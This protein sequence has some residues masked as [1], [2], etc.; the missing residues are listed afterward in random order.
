MLRVCGVLLSSLF[1]NGFAN[2]DNIY[3]YVN[4]PLDKKGPSENCDV[5]LCSSLIELIESS[6]S[7]I[8]FAIYGLR[9]QPYI[10]KALER[11]KNRGVLVRGIVD[12]TTENKSYYSDTWR[13]ERLIT[14]T[15]SDLEHD[16]RTLKKLQKRNNWSGKE[17]CDRPKGHV[18]PLQCFEGEGYASKADINFQGDIMHHKFF[19]V[20]SAVVWSGS[21][22]ISDTGVGGYNANNVVVIESQAVAQLFTEEFNRMFQDGLFHRGKGKTKKSTSVWVETRNK[23]ELLIAF[24]PQDYAVYSAV[25]PL[26][27][28]AEKSVDI[29]M[30]F[31]THREISRELVKAHKRGVSVRVILD[32][33]GA[34]NEY[35]KHKYLRDAGVP[36]KVENWGGK[37][38]MKSA[39]IDQKHLIIGS[40]NWTS[41]GESKNDEN[42]IVIKDFA[43]SEVFS[44]FYSELWR[45]I[46]DKWLQ[47]DPKPESLDSGFACFD[48]ID[49]DFDDQVDGDDPGCNS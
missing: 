28:T 36:V 41:A 30:F 27:K 2:A 32:A 48:G 29:A 6:N 40:M 45:S 7:T 3:L 10:L 23:Q 15:R 43:D 9:G 42:T 18:G 47:Y 5:P 14:N 33:T 25:M 46:D 8:D 37:M 12:K 20:D 44:A 31:L 49:N 4:S 35:S 17:K 11:A 39:L 34:T 21:A 24:S 13:L 16:R 19:V 22:N 38:H 26:L 1:I